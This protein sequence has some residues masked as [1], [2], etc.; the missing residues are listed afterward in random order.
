MVKL[1]DFLDSFVC[2]LKQD[3]SNRIEINL[4]TIFGF[5]VAQYLLLKKLGVDT[6]WAYVMPMLFFILHWLNGILKGISEAHKE[7]RKDVPFLIVVIVGMFLS[8][9]VLGFWVRLFT[10]NPVKALELILNGVPFTPIILF[11]VVTIPLR[12]W[13]GKWGMI[14]TYVIAFI[15]VITKDPHTLGIGY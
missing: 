9:I 14:A 4:F 5:L 7:G 1:L 8:C 12:R 10:S 11:C 6:N 13:L 3:L 2:N 15:L